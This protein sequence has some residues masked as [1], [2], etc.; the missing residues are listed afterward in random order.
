MKFEFTKTNG[1]VIKIKQMAA[2]PYHN[3]FEMI[4]A[5]KEGHLAATI[6]GTYN[7][8][9][10]IIEN[11]NV[12][13]TIVPLDSLSKEEQE[14]SKISR[15]TV[16]LGQD[17]ESK[18]KIHDLIFQVS[19]VEIDGVTKQLNIGDFNPSFKDPHELYIYIAK[20]L[21]FFFYKGFKAIS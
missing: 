3:L 4:L 13:E 2:V 1:L 6:A 16:L 7:I 10:T 8:P 9:K 18:R 15:I 11:G 5:C 12:V 21:I 20:A 14:Q 17:L 19:S